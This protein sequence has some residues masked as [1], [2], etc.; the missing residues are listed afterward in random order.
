[1]LIYVLTRS[2]DYF[3]HPLPAASAHMSVVAPDVIWEHHTYNVFRA[4]VADA[5]GGDGCVGIFTGREAD[6]ASSDGIA[7]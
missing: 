2:V 4:L 5:S 6:V 1:V 3:N 7:I